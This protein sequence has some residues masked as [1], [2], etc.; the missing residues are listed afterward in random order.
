MYF[1]Y[2]HIQ[3]KVLRRIDYFSPVIPIE[4]DL[5]K[6][7]PIFR[8]RP[9]MLNFGPGSYCPRPQKIKQKPQNILIGNSL[10]YTNNH[11]DIFNHLNTVNI[12]S[13]RR[14]I[15]PINYGIDYGKDTRILKNSFNTDQAIWLENFIPKDEYLAYFD[16]IT[17]AI[18][19]HIRQQAMGNINFCLEKGIKIYL[20]SDSLIYQQ[21]KRLGYIVYNIEYDLTQNSLNEVLDEESSKVNYQLLCNSIKNRVEIANQE[22]KNIINHKN[23]RL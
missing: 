6:K 15:I 11:L 1:H 2:K 19:G 22:I 10:S 13:E 5:M 21:L 8:A 7:N 9:F 3:N 12:N 16:Y 17:H 4:Y 20:Y 18:F 23:K 14:Y